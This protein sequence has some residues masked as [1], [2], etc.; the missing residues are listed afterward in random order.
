M[1]IKACFFQRPQPGLL[2]F[3]GVCTLLSGCFNSDSSEYSLEEGSRS[4]S[5]STISPTDSS[6]ADPKNESSNLPVTSTGR[7]NDTG[8]IWGAN[9]PSGVAT[10]CVGETIQAQDCSHG[11]DVDF[12]DDRDGSA[13]FSFTKLNE[14]GQPLS[15]EASAWSCIQDNVTGLIWET[16][17][18][19]NGIPGDEGLHDSDDTYTW[20][21]ENTGGWPLI[22]ACYGSPLLE[23]T[24]FCR[25]DKFVARVNGESETGF[26]GYSDWR[27]PTRAELR[28]IIDYSKVNPI[29]HLT[30]SV[31]ASALSPMLDSRFFPETHPL[32]YWT[33]SIKASSTQAWALSFETGN[34]NITGFS[35]PLPVRLVRDGS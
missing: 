29:R 28:S 18:G 32:N 9:Y 13:G 8:M 15:L 20:F 22:D 23:E 34:D 4:R 16:K 7:L 11:R 1:A 12:N 5:D 26:C 14:E 25:T 30:D 24:E 17:Q 6:A 19:G 3:T 21:N 27:V 31:D 2:I 33:H 35:A 10:G